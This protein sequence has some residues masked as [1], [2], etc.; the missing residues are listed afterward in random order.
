MWNNIR[1]KTGLEDINDLVQVFVELEQRVR[2]LPNCC[3]F[4]V[5]SSKSRNM[6]HSKFSD[7]VF[8]LHHLEN[9]TCERSE[10]SCEPNQKF[11][12]RR[13]FLSLSCVDVLLTNF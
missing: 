8:N 6:H 10:C 3:L 11:E 9:G 4:Q 7:I 1:S 12:G 2:L 13:F 5:H